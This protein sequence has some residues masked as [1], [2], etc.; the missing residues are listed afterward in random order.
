MFD[1]AEY[2]PDGTVYVTSWRAQEVYQ[3][4]GDSLITV[5]KGFQAPSDVTFDSRRHRLGI[6]DYEADAVAIVAIRGT[7]VASR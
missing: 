4:D 5:A 7:T 3:L 6:T 1:G 2:E